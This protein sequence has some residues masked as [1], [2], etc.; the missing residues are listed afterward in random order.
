MRLIIENYEWNVKRYKSLLTSLPTLIKKISNEINLKNNIIVHLYNNDKKD[1]RSEFDEG[2]I[3]LYNNTPNPTLDV[4]HELGHQLFREDKVS[5]TTKSK[6]NNIKR[7]LD[8]E[9]GDG[10]IFIND[11]TYKNIKEVFATLFKW[12]ILGKVKDK[13]YMEVLNNFQPKA[14]KIISD[15]VDSDELIKS[16]KSFNQRISEAVGLFKNDKVQKKENYK[17]IKIDIEWPSGTVRQ[18]PGCPFKNPMVKTSYGY[19]RNTESEDGEEVDI[20]LREDPLKDAKIYRLSQLDKNTKYFDEHKFMLGFKNKGEAR[21][22]Y[23]N[24]MPKPMC[25]PIDTMSFEK[26]QK[27][28]L[29]VYQKS[30]VFKSAGHKY[31][32]KEGKKYIYKESIGKKN[33]KGYELTPLKGW[34]K[35]NEVGIEF[36]STRLNKE[37][38]EKFTLAFKNETQAKIAINDFE[39]TLTKK[40]PKDLGKLFS[41]AKLMSSG[42]WQPDKKVEEKEK[43]PNDLADSLI[44]KYN[45]KLSLIHNKRN[46]SLEIGKI[47]VPKENRN[48][49]IGSKVVSDIIKYADKNKMTIALD[50]STDFGGNRNKLISFYKRFGFVMNKGKNKDYE[51]TNEMIRYSNVKKSFVFKI[52]DLFKSKKKYKIYLDMDG[53]ITDFDSRFE[54]LFDMTPEAFHK[55]YKREDCYGPIGEAGKVF[56]SEMKWTKDG[57]QLWNYLKKYKPTILS[58][59]LRN[60]SSKIGKREWIARELKLPLDRIIL[61]SRKHEYAKDDCILIDDTLININN[62]KEA[63][64]VAIQHSNTKDTIKKLERILNA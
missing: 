20:Y 10:R 9:K 40:N 53:V 56:W 57:K 49:G 24:A 38:G 19:V 43:S 16:N 1:I 3:H 17:G 8:K 21:T 22:A 14:V 55:I 13:G 64:G 15:I 46:N 18:W 58:T 7:K 50:P 29:K 4:I 11:H 59:P 31:I 61:S 32:R 28:I 45:I 62:F 27:E 54:E 36:D 26:F 25:G 34:G 63:K 47:I 23:C 5:V 30:L 12:W 41:D 39:E 44:N 35:R 2:I 6:L 60:E 51:F 48:K 52:L 42:I 33:Y 37:W